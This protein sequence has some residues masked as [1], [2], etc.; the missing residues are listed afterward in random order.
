M[1][2]VENKTRTNCDEYDEGG[3]EEEGEEKKK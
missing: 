1:P 3:D 2:H